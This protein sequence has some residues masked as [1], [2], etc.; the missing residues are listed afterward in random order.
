MHIEIVRQF[1][2]AANAGDIDEVLAGF[3]P[4]IEFDWT[5]SISPYRGRYHGAAGVTEWLDEARDAFS[6]FEFEPQEFIDH[7]AGDQL[8]VVLRVRGRGHRTS[9]MELTAEGAQ[10]WTFE[11]G[12]PVLMRVYQSK[13]EALA[14]WGPRQ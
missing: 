12:R 2:A 5:N 8:I 6:D 1:Y 10:V 4:D 11:R 7:P 13:D 9:A 14:A 3:D